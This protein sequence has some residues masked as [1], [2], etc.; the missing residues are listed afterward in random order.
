MRKIRTRK[1]LRFQRVPSFLLIFSGI[2]FLISISCP[3][4]AG[5]ISVKPIGVSAQLVSEAKTI[6][7]GQTFTVALSLKHEEGFHTYW[8]NPGI[9]G[10]ATILDWTLPEG[11]T[12][13][14]IQWQVPERVVMVV[15]NAH[16]YNS[17][18][19]LLVDI[20]APDVLPK[21]PITLKAGGAWMSC[22]QKRCCN[23]G[24]QQLEVTLNTGEKVEWNED[25]RSQ[26][27]VARDKIPKPIKGWEYSASRSGDKIALR[28]KN[29]EGLSV[30]AAK[31]VYFYSAENCINTLIE[32]EVS[33]DGSE[34]TV[35]LTAN[36]LSDIYK[37]KK[38]TGMSGLLYHPDGWPGALGQ[39]YMPV[40]VS[41]LTEQNKQN[42]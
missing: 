42:K 30:T 41:F 22:A 7:P 24:Y 35:V 40:T 4:H 12:A 21:G 32:Q 14:E 25:I 19:M 37:V 5:S 36:N 33:A 2:L 16:G 3:T 38:L 26:I 27:K 15:Y 8:V 23:V 39:K 13:G 20:T 11:F 18:A 1:S 31:G 28:V 9:V 29:K 34:L 6:V 17:D 10:I